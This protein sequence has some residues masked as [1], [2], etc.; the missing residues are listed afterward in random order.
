MTHTLWSIIVP[1][2][3]ALHLYQTENN[4]RLFKQVLLPM[5]ITGK[6]YDGEFTGVNTLGPLDGYRGLVVGGT[7]EFAGI[8]GSFIEIGTLRHMT[9]DGTMSGV[10]ELRVNYRPARTGGNP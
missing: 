4:W 9:P 10:M 8:T 1:G 7:G 5:L 2:R 3:G 6:D